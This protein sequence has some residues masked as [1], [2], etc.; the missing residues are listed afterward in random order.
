MPRSGGY[1][2]F[3]LPLAASIGVMRVLGH[4]RRAHDVMADLKARRDR[5]IGG[6]HILASRILRRVGKNP[7]EEGVFSMTVV[8]EFAEAFLLHDE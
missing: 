8:D 6:S 5:D 7:S 4:E 1:S 2:I 3:A